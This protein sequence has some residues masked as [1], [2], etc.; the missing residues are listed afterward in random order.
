MFVLLALFS[1]PQ[2]EYLPSP[3]LQGNDHPSG[4][5]D[6]Q[7]PESYL[8]QI[9]GKST[10]ECPGITW[11]GGVE[12]EYQVCDEVFQGRLGHLGL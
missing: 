5:K 12:Y 6:Q 8:N 9:H 10:L 2:K 7:I 3:W 4:N 1:L 11:G